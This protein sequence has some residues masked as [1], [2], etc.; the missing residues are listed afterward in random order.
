MASLEC[1]KCGNGIH[2]HG[3]PEGI[4]Y[5]YCNWHEWEKIMVSRTS[6]DELDIKYEKSLIKAW[7]CPACGAMAFFENCR[8][9]EVFAP[10]DNKSHNLNI[11][12]EGEY[13]VLFDDFLWDE[14]TEA[15]VSA[16]D[17]L[18]E[19]S[20]YYWIKKDNRNLLLFADREMRECLASY[21]KIEIAVE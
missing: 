17:I 6:S 18:D 16:Q 15:G 8:V 13:G 2:Y 7:K 1:S 4:E 5:T 10:D 9:T 19:Y 3:L 14:I 12:Q 11:V 21:T 20:G